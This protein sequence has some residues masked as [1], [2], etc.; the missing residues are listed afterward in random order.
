MYFYKMN[1]GEFSS[2]TAG[3]NSES[4]GIFLRLLNRYAST[5]KPI[6][7]EWVSL[8][9]QENEQKSVFCV[10]NGLWE[11]TPEGWVFP[12]MSEIIAQYQRESLKNRENGMKG[13]R[14]KK[15]PNETQNNR[16]GSS[17]LSQKTDVVN[18]KNPNERQLINSLTQDINKESKKKNGSAHR[19]ALAALPQPWLEYA[20]TARPDLDPEREFQDFKFY[21]TEGKGSS[22]L[23]SDKG[24]SQSWQGWVR[25]A[26]EQQPVEES[27]FK[28]KP[29]HDWRAE[30]DAYIKAKREQEEKEGLHHAEAI[31]RYFGGNA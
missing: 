4:V 10:L 5:E 26:S 8:G 18:L 29:V 22:K 30:Q 27:P 6:K 1:I 15:N 7:T 9:F 20:K 19:F 2:W 28:I 24:W 12:Q 21:F 17:G 11:E 25:R 16:V 31:E 3:L 14:P 13:G 23:R